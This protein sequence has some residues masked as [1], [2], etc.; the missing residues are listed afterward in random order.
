MTPEKTAFL[1]QKYQ[2]Q[3][4]NIP[5]KFTYV[6]WV[7]WWQAELGPDWLPMRGRKRGFYC[8]ARKRDK[9]PY[10]VWNVK[11]VLTENNIAEMKL[12]GSLAIGQKHWNASITEKVAFNI[13][14][15]RGTLEGIAKQFKI[16]K[17][18]VHSIKQGYSWSHLKN[19]IVPFTSLKITHKRMLAQDAI[20]IYQSNEQIEILAK[21]YGVTRNNIRMIRRGASWKAATKH[22][23]LPSSVLN[24]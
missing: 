4:R 3:N 17:S 8:M 6:Q 24:S 22:L 19:E 1:A 15:A 2:A 7:A 23:P 14:G 13:R 18:I 21:R 11:C 12:N 16:S 5:F 20:T 10:A 9:G